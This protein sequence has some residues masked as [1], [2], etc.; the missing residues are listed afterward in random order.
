MQGHADP[1]AA[2]TRV[3]VDRT[4][5]FDVSLGGTLPVRGRQP[6]RQDGSPSVATPQAEQPVARIVRQVREDIRAGVL[7]G[8][9]VLQESQLTDRFGVSRT[10]VREAISRLVAEGLLVKSGGRNGVRVFRPSV[11]ELTEMYEIR[12]ALEPLASSIAAREAGEADIEE[13]RSRFGALAQG[14]GNRWIRA[15]H[16][17]HMAV[18]KGA[19]RDRLLALI[20]QLR[21][22]SEPYIR[23][24]VGLREHGT[25]HAEHE[26]IMLAIER[27]D[28]E[29]AAAAT[30]EHLANLVQQLE[31]WLS[32]D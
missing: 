5:T 4:T 8:G 11:A 20:D 13:L 28:P 16:R 17:F 26:R 9:E 24:Y 6:S 7:S 23:F 25:L 12:M 14:A 22:Q 30:R 19:R 27:R 31:V 21:T 3:I 2:T 15:H 29:E 32:Q 10:P 1:N 18:Y